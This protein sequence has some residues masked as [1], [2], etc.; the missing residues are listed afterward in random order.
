MLRSLI[1][2][3]AKEKMLQKISNMEA[4]AVIIDLEDSV[5]DADKGNALIRVKQYLSANSL[6]QSVYVR[7]NSGNYEEE[8]KSLSRIG[9]VGFM[10]PKFEDVRA[11]SKC[12]GI[13]DAHSVIALVE[14]PMGIVNMNSIASC[15]WVD[16]VA[17]GAE[18]YTCMVNMENTPES[19]YYQ[20]SRL[21]TYCK[22]YK[23]LS[24][25][26][27]SFCVDDYEKFKK[28]VDSAVSLGFSGKLLIHPKHIEY[29]NQAFG[30]CDI[31]SLKKIVDQYDEAGLAVLVIEGRVY[32]KMHIDR[33]RRIIK[34]NSKI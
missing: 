27:P 32:E 6:S 23:K 31:P 9:N 10:L 11:Y 30:S 20:K 22:A 1:F 18:D 14:T 13:W 2:V 8:A 25:D 12:E 21:N 15:S 16:A 4:D 29:I 7:L 26:T 3:P 19:L 24:F 17:F 28:E 5:E 33:M 34:E